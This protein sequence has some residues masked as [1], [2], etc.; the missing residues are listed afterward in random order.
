MWMT[1]VLTALLSVAGFYTLA[2][3]VAHPSS[4]ALKSSGLA[5]SMSVY[6]AAVADYAASHASF[7]GAAAERELPFPAWY[8]PPSPRLWAN[9]VAADG[10]VTIYALA[11]P[12]ADIAAEI[13]GLSQNSIFA[14]EAD[15]RT[16]TL[17]SPLFGDTGIALPAGIPIE[18]GSP[19]WIDKVAERSAAGGGHEGPDETAGKTERD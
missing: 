15:T 14:G 11:V 18:N 10:T 1:M 4:I 19:V 6:R 8:A 13:A 17:H 3:Q 2:D 5:D 9:H 16:G 12:A 7:S